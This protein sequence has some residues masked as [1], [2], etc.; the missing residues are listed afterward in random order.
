[1]MRLIR[2][3]PLHVTRVL[4]LA[5]D[6]QKDISD[7]VLIHGRISVAEGEHVRPST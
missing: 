3:P 7:A 5:N 4:A 6:C 2:R 1:M